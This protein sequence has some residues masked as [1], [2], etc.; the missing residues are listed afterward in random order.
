[1][2]ELMGLLALLACGGL[3]LLALGILIVP[4]VLLFQVIGFGVRLAFHTVGLVLGGLLLLPVA[5][6][7][8]PI[9]ALV[10]GLLALKLLILMAPLLLVA[11]MVWALVTL[12]RRPAT[13]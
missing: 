4:F 2:F 13:A 3:V 6:L 11:L 7:M 8:L 9:V 1:M 12:A 10:G 5:A